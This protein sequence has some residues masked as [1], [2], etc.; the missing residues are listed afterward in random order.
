MRTSNVKKALEK[1]TQECKACSEYASESKR[2]NLTASTDELRFNHE[3][4]VDLKWIENRQLL[5]IVD[6]ATHFA[7]ACF[8]R[9]VS[10]ETV[11]KSF[12]KCW[13]RVYLGPDFIRVDQG[14]QFVSE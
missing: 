11:W 6:E 13:S 5:H 10:T 4:A 3:V 2:F 12:L 8:L 7:A 1:I 9:N 14:T